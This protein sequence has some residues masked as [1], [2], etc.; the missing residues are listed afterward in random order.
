[1]QFTELAAH[2]KFVSI[3]LYIIMFIIEPSRLY[4]GYEGNL[5]EKVNLIGRCAEVSFDSLTHH[6][7]AELAGF[8]LLTL[9]QIP[10]SVYL[11][12]NVDTIILPLERAINIILALFLLVQLVLGFRALQ[13]M[14]RAQAV[15]FHLTQF[16]R[17]ED[18]PLQTLKKVE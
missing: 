9:L 10:F 14:V 11:M 16:D 1:M 2:Y 15:K 8:W 5:R 18:I 3:T 12:A 4:L 17:L 6:Q 13:L 7:V